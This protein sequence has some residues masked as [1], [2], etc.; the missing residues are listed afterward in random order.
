MRVSLDLDSRKREVE[1][2]Q[3]LSL[4]ENF[5]NDS[6]EAARILKK[7]NDLQE[8]INQH[9]DLLNRAEYIREL[10]EMAESEDDKEIW[11]EVVKDLAVLDKQFREFELVVLFSGIHDDRNAIVSLHAGAGGTEAQDWVEMLFRMYTRW[12]EASSYGVEVLD[13]LDGDEAGIK[14]VTFLVKGKYAFGK[15]KCEEGVHRLIRIS[16]FDSSGR[17]HTSFASLS[18]LPEIIEDVEVNI[19]PEE[20]RIDTYRSGGAGG[21]HVNK[22]D[23]AVR[24]THISTGIVVQCQNERSQHANRLAAMKILTAKLYEIK[25]KEMQDKLQNLKGEYKEIAW[26]SQIRTYTLNPFSLVKDHRTGLEA[27]N[28]QSVLDGDLD[29][30][31]SAYLHLKAGS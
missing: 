27:G 23:S 21:Q 26:G 3:N 2:L 6:Q 16:P 12:A 18:V 31:I 9:Q 22:T 13:F 25:Q 20:L 11:Q 17:R 1:S 19:N 5:W 8:G 24:I 14:S 30:F 29:N 4:D 15:L 28:V 10:L 7:I